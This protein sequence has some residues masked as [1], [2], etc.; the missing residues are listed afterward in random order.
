M[1]NDIDKD[2]SHPGSQEN[3]IRKPPCFTYNI[4]SI[5]RGNFKHQNEL[6]YEANSRNKTL[7][8]THR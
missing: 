5:S 1:K 8:I 7:C 3:L 2:K 6:A 4:R